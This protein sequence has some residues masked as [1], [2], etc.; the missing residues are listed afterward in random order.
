MTPTEQMAPT[1]VSIV[2][3]IIPLISYGLPAFGAAL[4]AYLFMGVMQAMKNAESAGIAAVAGGMAEANV[5]IIATFY[6]ALLFGLAGVII[7]LVRAFTRTSTA[8]PAGWFYLV[9]GIIGLAPVVTLWQAQSL[10]VEVLVGRI[11]EGIGVVANQITVCLLLT[12][13]LAVIGA[14]ILLVAS[15]VPLPRFMRAKLK[16]SPAVFL[17]VMELVLVLLVV[18][19][20]MR[21][22][23]LYQVR[24]NERF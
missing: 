23:W 4:S 2:A 14:V 1:R 3:R 12:L 10:L 22:Y 24:L 21:T 7:G 5:A 9:T 15:L 20:H 11:Q 19:Y 16:W 8:S 18:I 6:I 17:I 13:T